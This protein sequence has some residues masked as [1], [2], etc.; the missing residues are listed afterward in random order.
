VSRV[1]EDGASLLRGPLRRGPSGVANAVRGPSGVANA[2]RGP[3]HRPRGPRLAL[4]LLTVLAIGRGLFWLI[5]IPVMFGDEAA[6]YSFIQSLATGH[7]IPVV[8][9]SHVSAAALQLAKSAP[10]NG[11]RAIPLP[12]NPSNA[13]WGFLRRQYEGY[14]TPFYHLLM[15]PVY[16]VGRALGGVLGS[17]YA[18]RLASLALVVASVP[19]VYLL[20]KEIFPRR[21]AVW[22]LAPAL[23]VG[24][25]IVN[26]SVAIDND[27]LMFLIGS[28][29]MLVILRSRHDLR[30]RRAAL[31]GAA[32]A[33]ALMSKTTAIALLPSIA[34]AI[35]WY[36]VTERPARRTT[37]CWLATA[38]LTA[39]VILVPWLAFNINE[40]G[41]LTGAKQQAKLV[42]PVIGKSPPGWA[43]IRV[44]LSSVWH[45]LFV[46]RSSTMST[47][48]L[49]DGWKLVACVGPVAALLGAIRARER[50]ELAPVIWLVLS[51]AL[52]TVVVAVGNLSQ[53]GGGASLAGRHLDVI[54]P[55]FFVLVAYGAVAVIG[56]R[57]GAALLLIGLVV[58]SF[59]EIP[60][61]RLVVR[62]TYATG[63][64][65]KNA[66][67]VQQTYADSAR[68]LSA[69]RATTPCPPTYVALAVV[70][71]AA[72]RYITINGHGAPLAPVDHG[73]ATYAVK[74][75]P[76]GPLHVAFS[77]PTTLAVARD[78][79]DG[80]V[81]AGPGGTPAMEVFCNVAQ[82]ARAGFASLYR[83]DHPFP[84]TLGALTAWPLVEAIIEAILA[85]LA[86]TLI[87]ACRRSPDDPT[88]SPLDG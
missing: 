68:R 17:F 7:G 80:A 65:G 36:V 71:D 33:L 56:W 34:M 16:W 54:A 21:E 14:Q 84:M 62:S 64:I 60:A 22:L 48:W 3:G 6:H 29:T 87:Y 40:Y 25:Q 74:S 55:L 52:G 82:P 75:V 28:V 5:T 11:A 24:M 44:M 43:G 8:G 35:G 15:V 79:R 42:E 86:L 41:A 67:V 30:L 50:R 73:W 66:P 23:L 81:T 46:V 2:V 32:V 58:A 51:L 4:G 76:R 53:A 39:A 45:T 78:V 20:A 88:S 77:G 85:G 83:P 12:P 26:S 61:D 69:V 63:T 19:A 13:G 57:L 27:S 49:R 47:R 18:L 38:A 9:E 72:P 10:V 1:G 37:V 31:A 70:Y 59:L